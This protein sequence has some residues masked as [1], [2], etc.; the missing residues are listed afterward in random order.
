MLGHGQ[1]L[2]KQSRKQLEAFLGRGGSSQELL[3]QNR[4][5]LKAFLPNF[6]GAEA[7]Y[8]E[9]HYPISRVRVHNIRLSCEGV[10]ADI[11]AVPTPGLATCRSW[12]FFVVWAVLSINETEWSAAYP[13]NCHFYFDP[14]VIQQV[15]EVGAS[16]PE[17]E[18]KLLHFM[19]LNLCLRESSSKA[20]AKRLARTCK[21]SSPTQ[22]V[23]RGC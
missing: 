7:I 4:K 1:K 18:S 9:A 20:R 19:K 23:A 12:P 17:G 10:R 16:W 13:V 14:D 3:K 15:V 8:K 11:Q 5:N 2:L 22:R 6:E 21:R